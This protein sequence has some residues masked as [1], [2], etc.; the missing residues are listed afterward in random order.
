MEVGGR[1]RI[2]PWS[3]GDLDLLRRINVPA[4]KAHLGGT[5]S[6]E[7][8]LARHRRYVD[9]GGTGSGQMFRIVLL[10]AADGGPAEPEAVGS[11]GYWTRVWQDE[12]VYEMGWSVLPAYQGRGVA[13][14]AAGAAVS[15]ARAAGVHPH[16][17]AFPS[18]VNGASNAICRKL[19]FRFVAEV[20]F[21]YP[22]GSMI[23]SNDWCLELAPTG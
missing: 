19:G 11:V 16:L 8:V 14:A 17:H 21:E 23:R 2:E 4:M 10:P 7:K 9:I 20:D 13:A 1:V 3:E 15:R 22:P 18:V 5:E 12:P 6:E